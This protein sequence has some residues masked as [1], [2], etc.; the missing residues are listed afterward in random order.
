VI[1]RLVVVAVCV[2]A[3]AGCGSPRPRAAEP[4]AAT[5]PASASPSPT[6]AAA[7]DAGTSPSASA[8]AGAREGIAAPAR[9][10]FP[11][12]GNSSYARQHHD[13]PASDIIAACGSVVRAVTDGMVLEVS[14]T[15][16]FDKETSGGGGRGGLSVSLLG[17]D[18]VRYYGSHF[19]AIDA[20]VQPGVRVAAGGRLG[21][22]GK[23]GNANN[24]CH[25]H[26]GISPVC[27]RTADWWI[28]RGVIW[29]WSYLDA[30]RAN[31]PKS[32]APEVAV[33][34]ARS[35]CPAEPRTS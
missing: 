22:V 14:R 33:W 19:S 29:P 12:D 27:A 32:P 30:W 9:Y 34:H 16:T 20:A 18:G 31:D 7:P 15:D 2:G 35:G 5:A 4:P 11:V 25:L 23:T 26:L 17:D 6:A 1:S 24:T 13:Y 8:S 21:L 10:V 3:L 28:R